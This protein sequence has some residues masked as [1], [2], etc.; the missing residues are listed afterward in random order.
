MYYTIY[1]ITNQIDGKIYIGS[2]KTKDLN[3]SYMGSGKY[4]K[5]AIQKHGIENF[6]KDIL[7]VFDTPEEMYAKEAD[8][9]NDDFLALENTYNLKTGGF[10]GFDYI[11]EQ[12]LQGFTDIETA[13]LGRSR[14]NQILEKKYG[15]NWRSLYLSPE[16]RVAASKKGAE[17]RK[18]RGYKSNTN[19]MNT[20]AAVERKKQKLKE[21]KHQQ[22]DRNSQ[23][24]KIWIT[25]GVSSKSIFK[26]DSM[27]DG[28]YRGRVITSKNSY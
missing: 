28:W 26:D 14:T 6:T 25:D 22:G 21:I 17:T 8:I 3:D 12:G 7:F 4:L 23:F 5:H 10:G 19:Q 18:R 9:V 27:P 20:P 11:N 1:K 2:H 13:K 15:P 24:G 16:R